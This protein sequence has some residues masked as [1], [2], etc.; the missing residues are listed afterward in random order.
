M[1]GVSVRQPSPHTYVRTR[2]ANACDSCKARKVKCDGKLPCGYCLRRHRPSTCRYSPQ[3]RRRAPAPTPGTPSPSV[4]A[5][6]HDGQNYQAESRQSGSTNDLL[7]EEETEVPREARLLCDAQGKLIFIGDCAPLSFFQTVRQLVN[8]R[9]DPQV[10]AH[11]SENPPFRPPAHY[12]GSDEPGLHLATIPEAISTYHAVTSGLVDL[13]N[14]AHFVNEL[15]SWAQQTHRLQDA[16]SATFYLVLAIGYQSSDEDR[17]SSYFEFARNIALTNLSGN[18][19]IPTIQS[20]ILV[21]LYMLGSCQMNGAFLFFGIAVRAAYSVGIHRTEINSRFGPEV[22]RQRDRLWKSL[23]VLDL[24]LSTSMGR[25]PATSDVD[26]T[27]LYRAINDNG[28]ETF[29]LLNASAQIFLIT[30]GIVVEVYSRRKVSYQL[31]EGISRQLRDWSMRWLQRLKDAVSISSTEDDLSK[32]TGACQVLCSYYYAVILVSRPFLMYELHKR[33]ADNSAGGFIGKTGIVSGKS[34]LADAC[35]DAASFMV[36]TLVN[37]T[38]RE[39]LNGH[40]PLIVSW[41]FASSL[42][43]GVG[44]L[45][46]FG[47][48]LEKYTRNSIMVLEHFA[49]SDAHA[50]QYSLIAKSLLNAALDYLEKKELQER[51]QRT[52]SSSQLFGLVPRDNAEANRDAHPTTKDHVTPTSAGKTLSAKSNGFFSGFLGLDSSSF[53]DLDASFLG[54]SASLPQTPDLSALAGRNDDHSFSDLNLFQL[55]DGDGHIDLGPYI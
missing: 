15:G 26:C 11:Q 50:S 14:H 5:R 33:L 48:I 24:F 21:T 40:M 27:V 37:L 4:H 35:I 49:K 51:T 2:V 54:L 18:I 19:N 20:F 8:T 46:S 28:Y 13:F 47:R 3:Q 32:I 9:V 36:D 1:D 55:L 16:S 23:R 22:H 25:P 41:L 6:V 30:E 39:Y 42:I 43:L 53:A 7:A 10:F 17:A 12:S 45:G 44:L 38:E 31:T 52:E 29:D 34:K